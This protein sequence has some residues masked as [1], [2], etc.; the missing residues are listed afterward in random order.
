MT[1]Y[2]FTF[3]VIGYGSS[4]SC[5]QKKSINFELHG[6]TSYPVIKWKEKTFTNIPGFRQV[7]IFF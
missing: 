3:K 4:S 1:Q 2:V 6:M 7:R 5:K